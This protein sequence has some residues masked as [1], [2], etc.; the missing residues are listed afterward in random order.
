MKRFV[1]LLSAIVV[2]GTGQRKPESD[3]PQYTSDGELI[4]PTNYREWVYLSSGLGMTYGPAA[5]QNTTREPAFDNVFVTRA[6]YRHFLETGAWPDKT[7]FALEIRASRSHGSINNG[8]HYQ[9]DLLGVEV[10][11]KD[12]SRP[13]KWAFYGFGKSAPAA[14]QIPTT[15]TCYTCHPAQGAVDNTFVQF[16]PELL[17]VARRKGTLTAAYLASEGK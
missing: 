12:E 6:A 14:K 13:A 8:G 2:A 17:E 11:V 9:T 16:Y 7:M 3:A 1:L 4:R 15:A 5:A 10:E